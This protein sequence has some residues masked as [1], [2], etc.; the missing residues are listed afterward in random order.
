M[1]SGRES[2]MRAPRLQTRESELLAKVEFFRKELGSIVP[3]EL[4]IARCRVL[5]NCIDLAARDI[6]VALSS[7]R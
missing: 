2:A 6:E 5:A 7:F 4:H 3:P 1:T